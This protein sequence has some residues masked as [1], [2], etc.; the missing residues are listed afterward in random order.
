MY[1]SVL[2]VSKKLKTKKLKMKLVLFA[3]FGI[4]IEKV[5]CRKKK[6]T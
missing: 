3:D 6:Y 4:N 1:I 5:Y 2:Q